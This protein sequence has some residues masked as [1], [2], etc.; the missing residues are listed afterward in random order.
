MMQILKD[1]DINKIE[2]D[3]RILKSRY[4]KLINIIFRI[5]DVIKNERAKEYLFHGAA[6]RLDVIERCVENIYSIFPLRRKKLL[7]RNELKDIDINLHAFFINI[8]GLLDNMAWV[9]MY[10]NNES[11][12]ID[13]MNVGLYKRKT[14]QFFKDDFKNYLNSN[15]MKTWHDEY[16]KNYRDTLSHRI[17]LYVPPKILLK[18][19]Q[20]QL[21]LIFDKRLRQ[22]MREQ[23]VDKIKR[24]QKEID[25]FG[26]PAA[27]FVHSLSEAG[28]KVVI[29]HRQVITDFKTVEEI[30]EKFC[31]MFEEGEA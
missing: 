7:C 9:I 2:K 13:K 14:Q 21:E 15:S 31:E 18:A 12:V 19:E 28:E 22:A 1:E 6:R 20:K 11:E 30:V 10:E 24:I 16:L 27:I 3:L 23:D 4:V 26:G 29:L 17:P 5:T 25:E 8:F